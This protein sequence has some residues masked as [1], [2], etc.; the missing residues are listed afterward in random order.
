MYSLPPTGIGG[1]GHAGFI[2]DDLLRAQ[3]QPRG[4]LGGQAERLVARIGVQRLRAA[5]HRR[6]RLQRSA[7]HIH[8]RLLR[9]QRGAGGL[10]VEAQHHGAGIS[11]AEAVA[12]EVRAYRRRAARNLAISSRKSLCALKKN[13]SRGAK[14]STGRPAL[15]AA[16]T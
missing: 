5:Q 4:F 1:V 7:D 3:R 14:A 10:R 8:V 15:S 6:Q 16:S 12:H 9:G 11:G 2:G 13:E